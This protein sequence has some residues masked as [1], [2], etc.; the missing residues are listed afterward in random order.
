MCDILFHIHTRTYTPTPVLRRAPSTPADFLEQARREE[1]SDRLVTTSIHQTN[2]NDIQAIN[3]SNN[4]L[5]RSTQSAEPIR[6][7]N[8]SNMYSGGYYT[9]EYSPRPVY[10]RFH[11]QSSPRYPSQAQ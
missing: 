6:H 11:H 9:T 2:D 10:N 3:H 4:L 7:P 5:Y 1:N 8:S